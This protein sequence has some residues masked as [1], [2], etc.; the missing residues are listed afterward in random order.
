MGLNKRPVLPPPSGRRRRAP[1]SKLYDYILNNR[2]NL[3]FKPDREQAGA[4]PKRGCIEQIVALR[5]LLNYS[6]KKW[7]KLFVG[8]V[9][10]SK[11]YDRVPRGSLFKLLY[12]LGCGT[13]MLSSIIAMYCVTRSIL[14]CV[15]ISATMGVRQ[16]SPTSCFLFTIFVNVL[17]LKFKEQCCHDGFLQWLHCLMIMYDTVILATSRA[18]FKNKLKILEE[19]CNEY[20]M[21]INADKTKFMVIHGDDS[22]R[23][24]F[25]IGEIIMLCCAKYVYLGATFTG[26]GSPLSSIREHVKDKQ[27][28]LNKL[29]IFLYKTKTCLFFV[30]K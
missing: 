2:L 18:M 30:K 7:K 5:L 3:W 29:I 27:K 15:I 8:F 16:G 11:A 21:V 10:F 6:F 12:K 26:D 4:Q 28:H 23:L 17:I 22:D 24:P 20:G 19:Y 13:A 1:I 9:D 25:S 14:G